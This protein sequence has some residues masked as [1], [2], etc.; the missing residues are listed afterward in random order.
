MWLTRS[1]P[2]LLLILT[3][4]RGQEDEEASGEVT[5]FECPPGS[6]G[7]F[8]HLEFCDRYFECREGKL[9]K[10]RLCGDGLG[11]DPD[12][13]PE[14][15]P[16]DHIHNIKGKCKSRPKL[17]K[18]QP[19]DTFC[20]RQNGVY[21]SPDP[22]EC[23][24]FYSCLN[25]VGSPQQ[26]ADGLHFDPI[27]GT[28]VWARESSRKGCSLSSA[29][30]NQKSEASDAESNKDGESLPNGFKCP[31]GKL[32]VHPALP[33]PDSCRLYYVCLNGITPNEAGCTSGLVFNKETGKCDDPENVPGC[34]ETYGRIKKSELPVDKQPS[35]KSGPVDEETAD[36]LAKLLTLLSNPKLK[37]FLKPEIVDALGI[38]DDEKQET[39]EVVRDGPSPRQ[40]NLSTGPFKRKKRPQVEATENVTEEAKVDQKDQDEGLSLIRPTRIPNRQSNFTSRFIPK[41]RPTLNRFRPKPTQKET[42]ADEQQ[43]STTLPSIIEVFPEKNLEL[44]ADETSS[45]STTSTTTSATTTESEQSST[46]P[47]TR[48]RFTR[49][50]AYK[51]PS[52]Q[53]F[54]RPKPSEDKT[55]GLKNETESEKTEEEKKISDLKEEKIKNLLAE[56]A[57]PNGQKKET[58]EDA[59]ND[60]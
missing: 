36:D 11:F 38:K 15:D 46:S 60:L 56:A 40:V 27:I 3:S 33:H 18:P 21:P 7:F 52:G 25:G 58:Q 32:G 19:G 44:P 54:R 26:C 12:K 57:N 45:T 53:G 51:G 55:A 42:Q 47:R 49:P 31:G 35:A 30:E 8:P 2:V 50:N 37:T 23:D 17:Q 24:K 20:P 41:V 28:C 34:E 1:L 10:K 22:T 4:C 6:D 48:L 29:S 39:D 43:A 59:P 16:C 13:D 14:E 9:V 5:E